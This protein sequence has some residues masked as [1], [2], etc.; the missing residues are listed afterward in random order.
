MVMAVASPSAA[1]AAADASNTLSTATG[2]VSGTA[3]GA[4]RPAGRDEPKR[5]RM[6][7]EPFIT[8]HRVG[9]HRDDETVARPEPG[10]R[11]ITSE[12]GMGSPFAATGGPPALPFCEAQPAMAPGDVA[13][14]AESLPQRVAKAL[15]ELGLWKLHSLLLSNP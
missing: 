13:R 2:M 1:R 10:E 5:S 4:V 14:Y 6:Y 15:Q 11:H 8:W 12:V 3:S 7:C 9:S